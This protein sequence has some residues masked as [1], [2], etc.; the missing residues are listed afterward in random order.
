MH[1]SY[2]HNYPDSVTSIG[3]YAFLGC[4]SLTRITVDE[5]NAYYK[6][7]DGN[8]YSKD[9]RTL[10]QY[11]I[12]KNDTSFAI[13]NGVTSIGSLAFAPCYS[14][15]SITIPDSVTSIGSLAFASC[16]SLTSIT[17]PDSVTSIGSSAFASC[18]S[19]TSITFEDTSTWC[20]TTSESDWNNKTNGTET[21]VSV[22]TNNDDYFKSTYSNYYWY[23][24]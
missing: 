18:Y 8:L 7:I 6:D 1:K 24:K 2:E 11:A 3:N 16:Y 9:G 19:L 15:T 12:G 10:I 20:R 23:K 13:P 14:L 17:I 21:D 4:T 22:P 5:N